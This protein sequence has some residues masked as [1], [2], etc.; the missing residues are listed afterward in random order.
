MQTKK[1]A[2]FEK[3]LADL[4]VSFTINLLADKKNSHIKD[5]TA[6]Q[7]FWNIP[8]NA[9][10]HPVFARK[11]LEH[12]Y[13]FEDKRIV[14]QAVTALAFSDTPSDVNYLKQYIQENEHHELIPY[15]QK[16]LKY[17]GKIRF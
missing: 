9:E 2:Q 15:I 13:L 12:A 7:K 14:Q 1:I 5:S 6:I 16:C 8:A 17:N 4:Q 11:L 10:L 3:L